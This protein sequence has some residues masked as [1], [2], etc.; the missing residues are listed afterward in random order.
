MMPEP[1]IVTPPLGSSGRR[2]GGDHGSITGRG[3]RGGDALLTKLL[4]GE[5]QKKAA[6]ASSHGNTN[7]LPNGLE[8]MLNEMQALGDIVYLD[9][10]NVHTLPPGSVIR[11]RGFVQDMFDAEYYNFQEST[12]SSSAFC[13]TERTPV[14]IT[15]IPCTTPWYRAAD[16]ARRLQCS[17]DHDHDDDDEG[18]HKEDDVDAEENSWMNRQRK[19]LRLCSSSP[20]YG[21]ITSSSSFQRNRQEP[22]SPAHGRPQPD[23]NLHDGHWPPGTMGSDP[24]QVSVMAKFYYE[25]YPSTS[26]TTTAMTSPQQH[27]MVRLNQVVEIVGVLDDPQPSQTATTTA[28]SQLDQDNYDEDVNNDWWRTAT[29]TPTAMDWE[30]EADHGHDLTQAVRSSSNQMPCVHVVSFRTGLPLEEEQE[31]G[32]EPPPPPLQDQRSGSTNTPEQYLAHLLGLPAATAEASTT[33]QTSHQNNNNGNTLT[34]PLATALYLTLLSQAEREP[35]AESQPIFSGSP[36]VTTAPPGSGSVTNTTTPGCASLNIVLDDAS[37][38]QALFQRLQ[39][40]LSHVVPVLQALPV[41][42]ENLSSS[43][44]LSGSLSAVPCKKSNGGCLRPHVLQ[45]PPGATLLLLNVD[46]RLAAAAPG[47]PR[48]HHHQS[49]TIATNNAAAAVAALH[50]LA[51]VTSGHQLEYQFEGPMRLA[52]EADWRIIVISIPATCSLLP[53]T[54][55]APH[56]GNP[57]TTTSSLGNPS[58]ARNISLLRAALAQSRRPPSSSRSGHATPINKDS[59]NTNKNNN[60]IGLAPELL[61]WA[62][63]YFCQVRESARQDRSDGPPLVTEQTFHQWLTWTRLWARHRG[64]TIAQRQDWERAV[65]LQQALV[66]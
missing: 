53:C 2:R 54:L 32:V 36:I 41:T 8:A 9:Q 51:R 43:S 65:A 42:V 3:R 66:S 33:V 64:S 25:L 45:L 5:L 23:S 4:S 62:P 59:S 61:E 63:K 24:S 47:Q 1:Q 15:P 30:V 56:C 20:A 26:S 17:N 18:E 38:A 46:E 10:S 48:R 12:S 16:E 14:V 60:N 44:S 39:H 34:S 49:T 29:A 28:T 22:S 37:T 40:T 19:R 21:V 27:V 55:Q 35:V 7:H 6:S 57:L 31:D 52:F 58:D 13:L 50:D 11:L